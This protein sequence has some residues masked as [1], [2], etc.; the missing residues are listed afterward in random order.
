MKKIF[1][2]FLLS[3]VIA[4]VAKQSQAQITFQK[5]YGGTGP[6][7][8]YGYSVQQ[9]TDGGYIIAGSTTNFGAGDEDIYLIRTNMNGDTLWTK[10]FGGTKDDIGYCVKQTTDGGFIITG[11]MNQSVSVGGDVCLIKTKSNGDTLWTKIIGSGND[12]GFYIVQTNDGGFIVAGYMGDAYLIRT[13]VN[14]D[15]LWT[16]TFNAGSANGGE[17]YSIHQTTDGG[18]IITGS[19]WIN[20]T[21]ASDVFLV[22]TD[23]NGNIL[24]SKTFGGTSF[25]TGRSVRQTSD[26][27]FILTGYTKSFGAGSS[28]VY[29]IRADANG[30]L[31]W[32]KTFG[33]IYDDYGFSVQQTNDNGFIVTG[34]LRTIGNVWTYLLKTDMNGDTLWTKIF[35][36]GGGSSVEQTSDGGYIIGGG[37]TINTPVHLIKTDSNGNSCNQ[38]SSLTI[39]TAPATI[40]NSSLIQVTS[41]NSI[42]S[43][44]PIQVSSG[45]IVTTLC[46]TG[47]NDFQNEKP[48]ITISPNPFTTETTLQITNYR[49]TDYEFEMYDVYGRTVKQFVIRNSDSFVIRR[50]NLPSG[51]YFYKVSANEKVLGTGK[52]IAE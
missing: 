21:Y 7:P 38:S 3:L 11:V 15:T 20:S 6:S 32:T 47:V 33:Y 40:I 25:D 29:L 44:L 35:A 42:I 1:F 17:G 41:S 51:I 46:F 13:D 52:I 43:S 27:G 26:G 31:L 8:D 49:M 2:I 12:V 4:S 30:N 19:V 18:F 48:E 28:D 10:T 37:R 36:A 39:V 45:G 23:G 50:G 34:T 14:G 16:K 24:W 22:K 5:T 9:T